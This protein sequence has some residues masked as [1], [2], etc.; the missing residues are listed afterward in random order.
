MPEVF[1]QP[2][3]ASGG[4]G[5][6]RVLVSLVTYN[7][8]E[9]LP[10]LVDAI[11]AA[12]PQVDVLVVDDNSPDGT[13]RWCDQ[14]AAEDRRLRCLHRPAKLGLGTAT[15]DAMKYATANGYDLLVNLDAD[16]SHPPGRIPDLVA[17]MDAAGAAR[18][19]VLI[20]SRYAPGGRIEGWPLRR[21]LMSRGVNLAARWLLGLAV[22]DCSGSM[23][24][25]RVELLG[26]LDF[27][28]IRG[29]GYA[30]LEEVLWHLKQ[31]GARMAELPIT[32]VDRRFGQSKINLREASQAVVTLLRLGGRNLLCRLAPRR[33]FAAARPHSDE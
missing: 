3:E 10:R 32:F 13:G 27:A 9:N 25:Y 28:A 6:G 22:R 33:R 7:E 8:I 20:G 1:T 16:F 21:R 23:R 31:H 29:R 30:F 15:I 18:L 14:R 4:S 26:R 11:F 17:G 19:D 12:A 2:G 24:C 5:G